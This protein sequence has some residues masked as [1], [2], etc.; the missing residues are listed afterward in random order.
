MASRQA[1]LDIAADCRRQPAGRAASA[2]HSA[3]WPWSL[4]ATTKTSEVAFRGS[5]AAVTNAFLGNV[6][7]RPGEKASFRSDHA[8]ITAGQHIIRPVDQPWSTTRVSQKSYN[9]PEIHNSRNMTGSFISG[10]TMLGGNRSL[11]AHALICNGKEYSTFLE[12]ALRG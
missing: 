4:T 2:R 11:T 6:P 5:S 8:R 9:L 10:Q 12:P 7:D 3:C 1:R